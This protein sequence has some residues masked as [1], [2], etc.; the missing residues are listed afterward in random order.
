MNL[1]KNNL[2]KAISP[3]LQQ[4][5]ENPIYWQE[6]NQETITYAKEQKKIVFLSIGY[7][8]CHWCHVMAQESF[9]DKAVAEYLNEHFVSIKVDREQ[10]PDIDQYFLSYCMQTQGQGGWPLN[11]FLTPEQIPFFATTYI[12]LSPKYG[13]P[14]F[15]E[16][17][18]MIKEGYEKEKH[19]MKEI[20]FPKEKPKEEEES[21]L[22]KRIYHA[23]D[24]QYAGFGSPKFPPSSTL[25]FLMLFVEKTKDEEAMYIIERTLDTMILRGLHDHL[26]G[27]FFRYCT[28]QEWTIP[29]FEKMLYD[30]AMLLWCYS[31]GYKLFKKEEYK[32]ITKKIIQCLEETFEENNLFY[33]AH[34]ADTN[35]EEGIT[36]LWTEEEIQNLLSD[37]EWERFAGVYETRENYEGKIHLLK[38][39]IVFLEEIEK[40][41]LKERKKRSQPFIDKKILTSWNALL[42]IALIIA[43]RCTENP[44]AREKAES[45]F[46]TLKEKHYPKQK[47][48]HS[49][50]GKDLQEE[51]FLEDYASFLLFVT[52]I[53][54]ETGKEKELLEELYR[55]IQEFKKETWIESK[56]KDFKEVAA[57]YFDHPLPS[58]T[59][60]AEYALLRTEILLEKEYKEMPYKET[61]VTDFYNC[62]AWISQGNIHIIH[63]PEKINWTDLPI[64]SLQL[65]GEILQDCYKGTC[66]I[67]KEKE[68]LINR[69]KN[70]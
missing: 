15:L 52:Y 49:S 25:I 53:Y 58:S 69:V 1:K 48:L 45:L 8:S 50:L 6:W 67:F 47:V 10:R 30:Q 26:G 29:H 3:Y 57:Q 60:M 55:K 66:R 27:G 4:H 2:D 43:S 51:E 65:K 24:Q 7:A 36:Y 17:L 44:Q 13:L 70:P 23:F 16:L 68:E 46:F 11:V 33:S 38:K 14:G 12:P 39:K 54:E 34:D 62:A 56:N 32:I 28:D 61:L 19:K 64:N 18:H 59:A 22:I 42:G 20:S 5:K 9:S 63:S 21:V 37:G 31:L 35:H 41:L 40:K